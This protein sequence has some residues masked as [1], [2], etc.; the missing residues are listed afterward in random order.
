MTIKGGTFSTV[1]GDAMLYA[2]VSDDAKG[3]TI[4]LYGKFDGLTLGQTQT[5]PRGKGSFTGTL[6]NN[7][8]S[9]T[10]TYVNN[11][12]IRLHDV[13]LSPPPRSRRR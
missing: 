7:T 13:A 5:L 1:S 4:D 2:G 9:Q 8:V 3:S 6:E 10:F 12:I 11:T